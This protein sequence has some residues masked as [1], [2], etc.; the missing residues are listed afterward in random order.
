[1]VVTLFVTSINSAWVP[2]FYSRMESKDYPA[3][4]EV[5]KIT[6]PLI[7]LVALAVCLVGPEVVLVV[8]GKNYADAVYMMP[9]M[10][11]GCVIRYV[12]TLYVNIEFYNKK[13][14]GISVATA[15]TA[16]IN[17]LMNYLL[18]SR[19]GYS[20]AAYA[21]LISDVLLLAIHVFIVKRQG[22]LDVFQNRYNI[23][24]LAVSGLVCMAV[25]LL[26]SNAMLRYA[27]IGM[28]LVFMVVLVL[29]NKN[30]L[31]SLIKGRGK[32]AE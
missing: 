17:V 24:V 4:R 15:I 5:T 21:T 8:G 19:L 11:F 23:G 2:W 30:M 6:I 10:I 9:P 31:I 26:Y 27:V 28:L 3:I 16:V 1:M 13:T 25:L 14:G 12:Y 18:I 7:S 29:K 32:E 22:K 20:A